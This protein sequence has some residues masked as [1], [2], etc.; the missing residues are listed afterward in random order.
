MVEGGA[1]DWACHSND[2][3]TAFAEIDDFD[4]AVGI[5]YEFY[6]AHPDETLLV[7]TA[8][9]ETDTWRLATAIIYCISISSSRRGVPCGSCRLLWPVRALIMPGGRVS[10]PFWQTVSDSGISSKSPKLMNL[11]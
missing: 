4:N 1:I 7:V 8:D 5:A 10:E 2:A 11:H 9:H 3:A 6:K